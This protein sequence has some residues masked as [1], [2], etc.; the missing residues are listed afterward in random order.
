MQPQR[1][2]TADL[3]MRR[4]NSS[5]ED[6]LSKSVSDRPG[7]S[8]G[9]SKGSSSSSNNNSG[10]GGNGGGGGGGTGNSGNSGGRSDVGCGG[11]GSD[12]SGSDGTGTDC[13]GGGDDGSGGASGGCNESQNVAAKRSS[14][15]SG[16]VGSGGGRE[17]CNLE[18]RLLERYDERV[19]NMHREYLASSRRGDGGGVPVVAYNPDGQQPLLMELRKAFGGSTGGVGGGSGGAAAAGG[20]VT[21]AAELEPSVGR[22]WTPWE[23]SGSGFLSEVDG[24][25]SSSSGGLRS[26]APLSGPPPPPKTPLSCAGASSDPVGAAQQVEDEGDGR[27]PERREWPAAGPDRNTLSER[28]ERP[29]GSERPDRRMEAVYERLSE[30]LRVTVR[31]RRGRSEAARTGSGSG[32]GSGGGDGVEEG[33]GEQLW[34]AV[35]GA[36]GSG[37]TTLAVRENAV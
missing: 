2:G 22:C 1:G 3:F 33:R 19:W 28:S 14:S 36:P 8:A 18:A 29:E 4:I 24:I 26:E 21:E 31:E 37:K 30:R 9:A 5:A 13:V 15:R 10:G 17:G 7:G 16:V 35:A 12:D 6:P 34:V 25:V 11:G 20:S 32:G 27:Q 23:T